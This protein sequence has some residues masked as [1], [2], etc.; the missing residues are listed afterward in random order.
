V[1]SPHVLRVAGAGA[2][3]DDL[4]GEPAD[5][6]DQPDGLPGLAG[7]EIGVGVNGVEGSGNAGDTQAGGVEG[8]PHLGELC[9]LHVGGQR[10]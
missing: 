3:G 6:A 2:Q 5:Q 9:V 1:G 10:R 4:G 7:A 8:L